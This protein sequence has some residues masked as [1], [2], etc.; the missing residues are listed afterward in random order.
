MTSCK[1]GI[2]LTPPYPSA[3][4]LCSKP[5]VLVPLFDKLSPSLRDVIIECPLIYPSVGNVM[6]FLVSGLSR[7]GQRYFRC[8]ICSKSSLHSSNMKKHMFSHSKP[9]HDPCPYCKKTFK[10]LVSLDQHI[11]QRPGLKNLIFESP[12][13]HGSM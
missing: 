8:L 13:E 1:F 7:D 11:R 12:S 10:N 9:T 6:E 2:F 5:Y 3:T 4:L